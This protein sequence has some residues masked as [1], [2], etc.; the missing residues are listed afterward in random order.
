M[1][2]ERSSVCVC[3]CV[4]RDHHRKGMVSLSWTYTYL[5]P[6]AVMH[7]RVSWLLFTSTVTCVHLLKS[8]S[9][10]AGGLVWV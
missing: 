6:P 8:I 4:E 1:Y 2:G 10:V 7:T 5:L 9:C 3:V